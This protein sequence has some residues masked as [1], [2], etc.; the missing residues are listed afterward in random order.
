MPVK[1]AQQYNR[2]NRLFVYPQPTRNYS[3][4]VA[5]RNGRLKCVYGVET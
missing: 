1:Y 5:S 4:K 3:I 2:E